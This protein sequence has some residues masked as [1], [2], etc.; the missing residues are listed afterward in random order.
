MVYQSHPFFPPQPQVLMA[1]VFLE[2][3]RLTSSSFQ[4]VVEEAF[5]AAGIRTNNAINCSPQIVNQEFY[6]RL[7]R[8]GDLG[9]GESYVEGWWDC[10]A[11]DEFI[12]KLIRHRRRNAKPS[13]SL[14]DIFHYLKAWVQPLGRSSQ[15]HNIAIKHYDL[16]NHLYASMLDERMTYTCGWWESG[17]TTLLHAQ[18]NKLDL[19]CKKLA[20]TP[21]M[22]IPRLRIRLGKLCRF[23]RRTL[24]CRG[25]RCQCLNRTSQ[26]R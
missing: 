25:Y 1:S 11:I 13:I 18:E 23:C 12:E 17:A 4:S 15:A 3:N 20:L 5:L 26:L 8:N 9:L 22:S 10:A 6:S 19:I 16:D 14:N 21:G 24:W 7:I 2:E